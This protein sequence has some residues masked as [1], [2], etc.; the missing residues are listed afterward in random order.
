[1]RSDALPQAVPALRRMVRR[2]VADLG[3][4]EETAEAVV[5]STDESVTNSVEHAFPGEPGRVWLLLR[6]TDDGEVLVVVAD[7][8]VWRPP[9]HPGYRGRGLLLIRAL[10][11]HVDVDTGPDGT[12]V[13]MRWTVPDHREAQDTPSA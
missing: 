5:L 6:A 9:T 10:A 13:G 2:W 7:D 12:T 11:D 8:G 3:L 4:D 1:V